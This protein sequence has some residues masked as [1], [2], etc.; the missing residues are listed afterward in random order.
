MELALPSLDRKALRILSLTRKGIVELAQV[1]L[2]APIDKA[3]IAEK[4][5]KDAAFIVGLEDNTVWRISR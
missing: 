3:I 2:A 1:E 5:G 4:S